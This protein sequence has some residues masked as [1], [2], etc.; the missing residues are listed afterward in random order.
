[1]RIGIQCDYCQAAA[2][3][4]HPHIAVENLIRYNIPG[5]GQIAQACVLAESGLGLIFK[6][7]QALIIAY[8]KGKKKWSKHNMR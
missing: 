3:R 2:D 1:M 8:Y 5:E 6:W 4:R 7:G